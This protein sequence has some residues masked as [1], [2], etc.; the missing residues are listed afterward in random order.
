ML[1]ESISRERWLK[2]RII[3]TFDSNHYFIIAES[4]KDALDLED[5]LTDT[6][7]MN[8]INN[9]GRGEEYDVH[10]NYDLNEIFAFE[11]DENNF[12][13]RSFRKESIVNHSEYFY[14]YP[15]DKTLIMRVY[16]KTPIY[17]PRKLIKESKEERYK[18]LE[19]RLTNG[20][21]IFMVVDNYGDANKLHDFLVNVAKLPQ[22]TLD[23]TLDIGKWFIGDNEDKVH[24]FEI[25]FDLTANCYA[26]AHN[27]V[28]P[29]G[30]LNPHIYYHFTDEFDIL[31]KFYVKTPS[32]EPRKMI[33]ESL[34][35]DEKKHSIKRR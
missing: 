13:Y 20:H 18:N 27:I 12:D 29:F 11:V 23:R 16:K 2:E 31:K 1:L 4:K 9:Y 8:K 34:S 32:Y 14:K 19:E 10:N 6:L 15:E 7:G 26:Y 33:R 35:F 17:K 24:F 22:H 21:H 3:K 25:S 5:F 28:T 30:G